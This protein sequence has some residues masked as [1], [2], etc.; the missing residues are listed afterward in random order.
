MTNQNHTE[1]A[2]HMPDHPG[3]TGAPPKPEGQSSGW[4]LLLFFAVGLVGSLL[5]SWFLFPDLLYSTKTQPIN[6]NHA[7]HMGVVYDGCNSC[8]FFRE[9]GSFSGIPTLASCADCH[10]DVQGADPEEEKFVNEYVLQG[11]EVPWYSYADQPAC[12]FFS[13]AA[14][15]KGAEMKCE[16]CHGNTGSSESTR[17]YQENRIT[18]YSRDIWGENIARLGGESEHGRTMKMNDCA[19]CHTEQIGYKGYCFQCHK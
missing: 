6:F 1:P 10:Q 5:G 19:K 14:H 8:H 12:V 2:E 15:V 4:T 16:T 7:L 18:G 11:K 9:D 13:H 17:P 3:G